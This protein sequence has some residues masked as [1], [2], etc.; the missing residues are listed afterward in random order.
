MRPSILLFFLALAASLQAQDPLL[1]QVFASPL[2]ISPAFAGQAQHSRV[3]FTARTQWLGLLGNYRTVSAAVDG[4]LGFKRTNRICWGARLQVDQSGA[5]PL[6][7]FAAVSAWAYETEL[8]K[9]LWLRG[10]V[11]LGL[12]QT[13]LDYQR[14]RFPDQRFGGTTA[15]P[16]I[17]GAQSAMA[18]TAEAGVLLFT[19]RWF[20]SL[21]GQHLN[22]PTQNFGAWQ[23]STPALWQVYSGLKVP[24]SGPRNAPTGEVLPALLYRQQG[25]AQ[26]IDLLVQWV[27]RPLTIG[28]GYR[29][30]IAS[31]RTSGISA[32]A[33]F[34]LKRMKFGYAFDYDLTSLGN[35]NT[36]GAH[37]LV[38]VWRGPSELMN[39]KVGVPC[40]KF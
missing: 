2:T 17:A 13:T 26:Q 33:G 25:V 23:T 38:I 36:F 35:S 14:L 21:S 24:V 19:H 10:G 3:A 29:G 39:R 6:T 32:I 40:P 5:S 28:L 1:T 27:Q 31:N 20:L 12:L 34:E 16:A 30:L 18:P 8:N 7:R 11:G 22:N 4:P 15:D 37:E 9:G